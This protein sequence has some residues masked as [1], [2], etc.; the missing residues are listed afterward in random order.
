ME[1]LEKIRPLPFFFLSSTTIITRI[2]NYLNLK[3]KVLSE[4]IG[5]QETK[6]IWYSK[7]HIIQLLEEIEAVNG[8]GVRFY[9]GSYEATNENSPNQLC[10]LMVTT[11]ANQEGH[12]D[13]ILEEEANFNDRAKLKQG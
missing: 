13:V 11:R 6:C 12:Q 5:K 1:I 3:Y 8:D 4:T 9:L 7:E 2:T 10:L